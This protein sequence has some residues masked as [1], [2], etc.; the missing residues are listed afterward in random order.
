MWFKK[1]H[2]VTKY[3]PKETRFRYLQHIVTMKPKLSIVLAQDTVR[4]RRID[5]TVVGN[6]SI[7]PS[8]HRWWYL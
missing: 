1:H 5:F 6:Q 2:V 4:K 8:I 3:Q 7:D